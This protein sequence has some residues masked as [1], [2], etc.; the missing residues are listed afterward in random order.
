MLGRHVGRRDWQCHAQKVVIALGSRRT[1]PGGLVV[2]E[3]I[4]EMP[5]CYELAGL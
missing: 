2:R 5:G 4:C 3:I 1:G